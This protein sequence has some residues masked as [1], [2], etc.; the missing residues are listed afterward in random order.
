M[1]KE[2]IETVKH[3]PDQKFTIATLYDPESGE[4]KIGLAFADPVDNFH[5]KQ[6]YQ[7]ARGRAI[8]SHPTDIGYAGR[9]F[10]FKAAVEYTVDFA[11]FVAKNKSHYQKIL[12]DQEAERKRQRET[13]ALRRRLRKL[14]G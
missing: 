14:E 7:K 5:K 13:Q 1:E 9:G 8:S 2:M 10:S 6:G 4:V 12:H 11:Q 3:Y